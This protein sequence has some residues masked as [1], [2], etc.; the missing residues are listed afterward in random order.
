MENNVLNFITEEK[1]EATCKTSEALPSND[2]T[3]QAE[4][5]NDEYAVNPANYEPI[6]DFTNMTNEQIS[7]AA[8][9]RLK[10][11]SNVSC[12]MVPGIFIYLSLQERLKTDIDLAKRVLIKSKKLR[13]AFDYLYNIYYQRALQRHNETKEKCICEG[14][15]DA[16]II[17]YVI[18]Y[19][20]LDDKVLAEKKAAQ[21]K[22]E[23]K[24]KKERA[25]KAKANAAA[26]KPVPTK[27]PKAKTEKKKSEKECDN[28]INLM[29]LIGGSE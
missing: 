22:A 14:A 19:Y 25:E 23:E 15:S 8:L 13:D 20:M 29:D 28:Q 21:K 12:G 3:A 2:L 7:E 27:K 1:E 24:A 18:E 5:K 16:E 4:K 10:E 11:Q 26:P 9:E 17:E 6:V